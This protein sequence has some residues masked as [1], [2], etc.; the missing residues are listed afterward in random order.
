VET[1]LS[2]CGH[3][4]SLSGRLFMHGM[5]AGRSPVSNPTDARAIPKAPF[6]DVEL[7]SLSLTLAPRRPPKRPG[8]LERTCRTPFVP[9]HRA[10]LAGAERWAEA[11]EGIYELGFFSTSTVPAVGEGQ[12]IKQH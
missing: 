12:L 9:T 2:A 8:A 6:A 7:E 4:N 1:C 5:A 10:P 3:S 11:R